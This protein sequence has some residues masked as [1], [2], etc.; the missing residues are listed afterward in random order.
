[1]KVEICNLGV[2]KKAE[3]DLKPLTVFIGQNGEGK[4]WAAYAISAILGNQGFGEYAQA[5]IEGKTKQKYPPLDEA[6]RQ[7]MEEGSA[8]IDVVKFASDYAEFYINDVA[9][10]APKL[11]RDFMKSRRV[12]FEDLQVGISLAE[13]KTKLID[14]IKAAFVE[15]NIGSDPKSKIALLSAVKESEETTLYFYSS[16]EALEKLPKRVFKQ[17]VIGVMF[18]TIQKAFFEYMYFFPT[19]RTAFI[20]FPFGMA[21]KREISRAELIE[22]IKEM[23]SEPQEAN[24]IEPVKQLLRAILMAYQD[25]LHEREEERKRNP[26]IGEY[27]KLAELLESE[28]IRG[29]LIFETSIM[30]ELL[31]QPTEDSKLEMPVVSSMVKELAP[32]VL[33]LRYLAEPNELLVFDE[34]EMNLH[35]SVQVEIAEFLAM[36]VNAGLNVLITTHSPYIVDH[37]V[38][39]MKAAKSEEKDSIKNLFY[40]E[41]S[42]AFLSQEQVSVYFFEDGNAKNILREDGIIDWDTFS[43]VSEDVSEIYSQLITVEN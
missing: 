17:F 10:F 5:Y 37:L 1:M 20:S 16:G 26:K 39:L 29:K 35:P 40:L 28:I 30:Q 32:L 38:N 42:Q 14:K 19:E 31:F 25:N 21:K 8:K 27:L 33:C 18:K 34:P 13:S 36:L 23:E 43:N 15:E 12:T 7:V 22:K 41:K 24:F 9:S 11:M 4:S 2:I 3:I 6:I